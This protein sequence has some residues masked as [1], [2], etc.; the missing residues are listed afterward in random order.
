MW[1]QSLSEKYL[2]ALFV[3]ECVACLPTEEASKKCEI[4]V[5]KQLATSTNKYWDQT[6][7]HQ[8]KRAFVAHLGILFLTF[9]STFPN[10]PVSSKER[11]NHGEVFKIQSQITWPFT[12]PSEISLSNI[13]TSKSAG[14]D[15]PS[16]NA[17]YAILAKYVNWQL[18]NVSYIFIKTILTIKN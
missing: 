18:R 14:T 9:F 13:R 5:L 2:S 17:K 1:R 11:E 3:Q 8:C 7:E 15:F 16:S 12:I 6:W 10:V 4:W